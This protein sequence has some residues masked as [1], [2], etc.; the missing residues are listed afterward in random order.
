MNHNPNCDGS[1]CRL[2][3]GEV[4]GLPT[5]GGANLILCF[6]CH[7]HELAWRRSRNRELKSDSAFDLPAWGDLEVYP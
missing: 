1:H 5:G 3:V 6:D 4:R 2:S 7:A